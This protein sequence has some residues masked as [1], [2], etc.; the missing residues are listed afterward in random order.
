MVSTFFAELKRRNV[1]KVAIAY[2]AM[3][4]VLIEVG[5]TLLPIFKAPDWI[6]QAVAAAVLLGF[7]VALVL[8]WVFELTP[9]GIKRADE[10]G[11]AAT[12][13]P[14]RRLQLVF[15]AVML[16]LGGA[17]M[18]G[19][20]G[21]QAPDV[22]S[23]SSKSVA[24]LPFI[25][26]SALAEDAY[27]A[28]GMHDELLTRLSRIGSL[29]VISRT[30][31]M[32]FRDTELA[33][34]DI[35]RQLGVATV[36]EG[37]VQRAADQVRVNV[38]LV[39]AASGTSIWAN[40][41]DRA[42]NTENLFAI[43]SDITREI[44]SALE[45]ALTADELQRVDHA[46][47]TNLQ[48]YQYYLKGRQLLPLRTADALQEGRL[49]AERAV[50]LDPGFAAALVLLADAL[51]LLH[52]YVGLEAEQSLIP[53]LALVEQ[54]MHLDPELAEAWAVLGEIHRHQGDYA[55]SEAAFQKALD[56]AP[57]EA[58]AYHWFSV[59]RENQELYDEALKLTQKAHELNPLHPV[60]HQNL[61][62]AYTQ[63]GRNDE[64][65]AEYARL[66]ELHPGFALG[67]LNQ[68]WLYLR[69]GEPV[70]TLQ[71]LREYQ[72]LEPGSFENIYICRVLLDLD[73]RLRARRCFDAM[74]AGSP[75]DPRVLLLA[76][77]G[78]MADGRTE[79]AR[80]SVRLANG[81]EAPDW[82]MWVAEQWT[83]WVMAE[84]VDAGDFEL[85]QQL[86]AAALPDGHSAVAEKLPEQ[87][88]TVIAA[89]A[90]LLNAGRTEQ[91]RELLHNWLAGLASLDR[92]R[93]GSAYGLDDIAAYAL[94][95]DI[96][97]ALQ[98][99][100]QVV[101][102]PFLTGW[103]DLESSPRFAALRDDSRFWQSLQE[104][105]TKAQQQLE[106]AAAAGLLEPPD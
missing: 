104:L 1:V 68:V 69:R 100:E 87:S 5:S 62:W 19:R 63:L 80:H 79:E 67:W 45:A 84:A 52:E 75:D 56:L 61:A 3:G 14:S 42:L 97:T 65:I 94:A 59:L 91:A 28:D 74:L 38:Q 37:G 101:Q 88:Y 81:L 73:D 25:N 39:D 7:P 89:A 23:V 53:A 51:H 105:R 102:M 2:A 103:Q 93:G 72:R 46:P 82:P 64:A 43:Q 86:L 32:R 99:L 66:T 10:A 77:Y 24:V 6:L 29:K 71:V 44:S 17:L 11:L 27:F 47:T 49:Y 96:D 22:L 50:D 98:R 12:P 40:S 18:V 92:T 4:W 90:T 83:E 106:I 95:G 9:D 78:L 58:Q 57:G 16:A 85:A 34:Q 35:A 30:S 60:I 54:A 36:L 41:Y 76:R 15:L 8:S 55:A 21:Q 20:F 48:A 31:V 26:R 13:E 70:Q 33:I